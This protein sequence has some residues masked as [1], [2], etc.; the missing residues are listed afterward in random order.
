[1]T[2]YENYDILNTENHPLEKLILSLINS[3]SVLDVGCGSGIILKA[4]QDRGI[5]CE[6]IDASEVAVKICRKK[7]LNVKLSTIANF[8][9]DKKY[10]YVICLGT[11]YYLDDFDENFRKIVSFMKPNGKLIVNFHNPLRRKDRMMKA[12]YWDFGRAIKES[13]LKSKK[14]WGH[15]Y[16]LIKVYLLEKKNV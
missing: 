12:S 6:G 9:P 2:L 7:G 1:M 11:L 3:G 10:D 4:L 16:S 8:H 5:P 15:F 13:N 14:V